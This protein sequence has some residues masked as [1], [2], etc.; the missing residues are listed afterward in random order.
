[1]SNYLTK[2]SHLRI[3]GQIKLDQKHFQSCVCVCVC[4]NLP[5]FL[6]YML[7]DA[8]GFILTT[9]FTGKTLNMWE[10]L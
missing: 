1:M 8:L 2:L 10:K 9:C 3:S 6:Q 7:N 5:N 4:V